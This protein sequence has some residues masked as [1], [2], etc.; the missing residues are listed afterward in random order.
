M[1]SYNTLYAASHAVTIIALIVIL[2]SIPSFVHTLGNHERGLDSATPSASSPRSVLSQA[3]IPASPVSMQ[4]SGGL[5]HLQNGLRPISTTSQV[6]SSIPPANYDE[7]LGTT[8]TQSFVS[9]AYNVTAVAQSD[10]YGYGPAYLLNGLSSSGYWYQIGISYDWPFTAGGYNPGF[11]MNYEVFDPQVVSVFPTSGGGG[12][13][14][15]I[16][17]PGDSVLLKLNFSGRNVIMSVKDWNTGSGNSAMFSAE[18]AASFIGLT[19]NFEQ[20]GFFT[21]LMTEWYH[22]DP[23]SSNEQ[24]STYSNYAHALSSAWMWMD[25]FD[26]ATTQLLFSNATKLPV[27]FSSPTQLQPF[28]SHGAYEA[29]D[30]YEFVTGFQPPPV[31]VFMP[32]PRP[33]SADV[34]QLVSFTCEA[35]GGVPPFSYSWTFGDGYVTNGQNVSHTFNFPGTINVQCIAFDILKTISQ[36]FTSIVILLDPTTGLTTVNPAS[37]DLGQKATFTVEATGGSGDY[38]YDWMNLPTGCYSSNTASV[39]CQPTLTGTFHVA[40]SVTDSNGFSVKS[41]TLSITVAADPVLASFTASPHSLDTGQ[42][43]AFAVSASGG[44]G[45]LS[46]V[47]YNLPP[48]CETSNSTSLSC[49]PTSTGTYDVILTMTDSNG[50]TVSSGRITIAVNPKPTATIIAFPSSIDLGQTLTF[51]VSAKD[52]TGLFSYSYQSLPLGCTASNSPSLSCTPSTIGNYTVEAVVA[53]ETGEKSTTYITVAVNPIIRISTFTTSLTSVD[54]GQELTLTVSTAGGTS[55]LTYSYSGLPRGCSSVNSP[56]LDCK[57]SNSGIYL[58][59]A[60]VIDGAGEDA[61]SSV[62]VT[63]LPAKAIGL[64]WNQV[65]LVIGVVTA[66]VAA[67]IITVLLKRREGESRRGDS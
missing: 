46:L 11:G 41:S 59:Q 19:N 16:V 61:S 5:R 31:H 33:V 55:P 58:V 47:Y 48:G 32:I 21:G 60:T 63:V 14:S 57:P 64:S 2:V 43:I 56:V 30:P 7:Q 24:E 40:A 15:V 62:N 42:T 20:N 4:S 6:S 39:S 9:I 44:S 23:Y 18:R 53:D 25:E 50:F 10:T 28:T 54:T 29:V 51:R 22:V 37:I 34:G 36:N 65:Y 35:A 38:T 12:L 27:T 67:G 52:G 1:R 3:A 26:L 66:V 13:A 8:F 45:D 49:T 17:N